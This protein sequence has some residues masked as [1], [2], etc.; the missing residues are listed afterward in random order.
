MANESAYRKHARAPQCEAAPSLPPFPAPE[1]RGSSEGAA[2][3]PRVALITGITGQDGSY[4]SELLLAKGYVVHGLIRRSSA[5][6]TGRIEHLYRDPHLSDVRL[7]LHYGDLADGSSLCA[8]VARVRPDEVYNLGAM[9]HVKVSFE[10]PEYTADVDALGALRLLD[11]IRICGLAQSTRFYQASTSELFGRVGSNC[12]QSE[13]TPFYPRSPYGVAKQF[14]YWTVVN[15]REAYGMYC[16]NG[17][18]FNHE[19]P[20]RGPTFVTR[21]ITRAVVRIAAGL[22]PDGCGGVS[23]SDPDCL[24]IGNLDA[25]RDWGHA[26]D[27]VECMW[28]MLQHHEPRDFVVATGEA[29]SVR[30]F[31]ELAFTLVGIT[32]HWKGES[33]S[34]GEVGV[35]ALN[36]LRVLVRVDPRY[37]RPTEVDELVGDAARA[38][39]ELGWKPTILFKE[40]VEEMIAADEEE[41]HAMQ[42]RNPVQYQGRV[43]WSNGT[44]HTESSH[45]P[46]RIEHATTVRRAPRA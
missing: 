25:K 26:R 6:N 39:Q 4:L 30:E 28:R 38:E 15:Y 19:S 40:L 14:A 42:S 11:A 2:A 3:K 44:T 17:I 46:S 20:R 29:H 27:Y 37:F 45:H 31:V 12:P 35:D 5:F 13:T 18:L 7:F 8:I 24:Y 43:P 9:S 16:V 21:K 32:V 10:M 23:S 36:P 34:I 41:L 33:G 22:A 1:A